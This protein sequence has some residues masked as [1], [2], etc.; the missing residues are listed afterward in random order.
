VRPDKE[1]VRGIA[2]G[3]R[4]AAVGD[5]VLASG[6][7]VSEP[8]AADYVDVAAHYLKVATD[9]APVAADYVDVAPHYLKVATDYPP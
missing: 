1:V 6:V 5:D 3:S 7:V 8:H 4:L 2:L 9:Y